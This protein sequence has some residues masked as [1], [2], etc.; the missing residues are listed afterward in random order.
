LPERKSAM[1]TQEGSHQACTDRSAGIE[2]YPGV[3]EWFALDVEVNAWAQEP[4]KV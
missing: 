4:L 3:G 2:A 1:P